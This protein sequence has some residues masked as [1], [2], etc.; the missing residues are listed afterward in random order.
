MTKIFLVVE[1]EA[2]LEYMGLSLSRIGFDCTM[3]YLKG[4]MSLWLNEGLP[5]GSLPLM[6]PAKLKK[7]DSE[8]LAL[9]DVRT[10]DEWKRGR[11][12]NSKN[13]YVGHL[14]ERLVEVSTEQPIVTVCN[15]GMRAGIAASVLLRSGISVFNLLGGTQAWEAYKYPIKNE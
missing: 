11:I 13:V 7:L 10:T 15:T 5:Y 4:G 12:A 6:S 8:R 9:L 3:G 1:D 2:D 14:A